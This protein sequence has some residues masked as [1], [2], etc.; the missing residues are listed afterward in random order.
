M[1]IQ[2]LK[3]FV[4][5]AKCKNFT[6]ASER[7]YVTQ[8]MLTRVI[9][10]LEAELGIQLIERTSKYFHLTDAGETFYQQAEDLLI[11]YQNLYQIID[12]VKSVRR[13]EVKIHLPGVLLDMFFAPLLLL[14]RKKYPDIGISIV[15]EGS[16]Q[17]VDSILENRA[18]LGMVMLP[19]DH[20]SRLNTTVVLQESVKIML[21][22]NHRLAKYDRISV[23]DLEEEQII[24]FGDT[25]TLY[26]QFIR[27]CEN[28]DFFPNIAY[29]TLMPNF[30]VE[31][32]ESSNCIAILPEPVIR[33]YITDNLKTISLK[34]Y[35]P[36]DI[37]VIHQKGY[38]QSFAAAKLKEFI[39]SYFSNS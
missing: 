22:K 27:L 19:V 12:D 11:R 18:D 36:W 21:N 3:Y 33:R 6:R 25:A 1:E 9:K 29:K 4:E 20:A 26:T 28:N 17:V 15:E 31:M 30:I 23:K 8:P 10:Q 37:A 16:I 14:F 39:C 2:Q 7:L 13:G 34:Q 35:F 32:I 38:Y 5:I 24:T